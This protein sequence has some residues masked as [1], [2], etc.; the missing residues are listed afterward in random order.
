[1]MKRILYFLLFFAVL[2]PACKKDQLTIDKELIAD[3]LKK[4]NLTAKITDEGLYYIIEQEGT[5]NRPLV[6]DEVK[7]HYKG[8]LLDGTKFD[9]SYDRG[10]PATFHLS[11]VIAGWQIGIPLFKEGGKGKLIVPSKLGYGANPPQGIPDNAV[12]VVDIELLEVL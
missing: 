5:G 8:T 3:Y 11:Q 4:N 6:S 10:E 2:V 9:S 12:L 7:V 1:M